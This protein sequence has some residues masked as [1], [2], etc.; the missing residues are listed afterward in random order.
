MNYLSELN[1]RHSFNAQAQM[2]LHKLE[3]NVKFSLTN[4]SS[5][6][7]TPYTILLHTWGEGDEEVIFEDLKDGSGK[8]KN[9][10]KKLL[11]YR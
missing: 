4:D 1:R 2:H 8:T 9:G 3:E 11:F 10:Y 7:I 6:P 5:N